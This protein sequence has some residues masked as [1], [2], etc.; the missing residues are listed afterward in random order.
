[1]RVGDANM[2][3]SSFGLSAR[4]VAL[5]TA[6]CQLPGQTDSKVNVVNYVPVGNF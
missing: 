2:F 6:N 5:P 4:G 3:F 1:M